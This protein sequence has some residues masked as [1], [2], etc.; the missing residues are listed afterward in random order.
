MPGS[1]AFPVSS[2]LFDQVRHSLKLIFGDAGTAFAE[3]G[4]DDL[5][6]RA[7]EQRLDEV[8]QRRLLDLVSGLLGHVHVTQA[9]FFVPQFALFFQY[10]ELRANRGVGRLSRQLLLN[11]GCC[12]PAK[13]VKNVHDLAFAP[14]QLVVMFGSDHVIAFI[15]MCY[16]NSQLII[17][18]ESIRRLQGIMVRR[19]RSSVATLF[20]IGFTQKNAEAFFSALKKARVDRIVDVRLHN[21]GQLAGFT[22]RDDLAFFLR[23]INSAGYIH[24]PLLAPTAEMLSSYR[25]GKSSWDGYAK[26]FSALIRSR[27]IEKVLRDEIQDRDCLLCSEPT[28]EHCHR[29][30]VAEHLQRHWK[31]LAIEHL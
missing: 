7:F 19:Y 10:P 29:R 12:R 17:C 9:F 1:F 22:K 30:L 2:G 11:L 21:S 20:T 24:L 6:G 5:V 25:E 8:L 4:S 31:G 28:A 15:A 23:S 16:K 27:K 13:P 18:C 14:A 3:Q 26:A